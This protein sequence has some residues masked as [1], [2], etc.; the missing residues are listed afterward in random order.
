LYPE[1]ELMHNL[2]ADPASPENDVS[3]GSGVFFVIEYLRYDDGNV[4]S[5]AHLSRIEGCAGYL[6]ALLKFKNKNG[7][8][9]LPFDVLVVRESDRHLFYPRGV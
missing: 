9:R 2:Q 5:S 7:Y 1:N 8:D 3:G 6:D 4:S